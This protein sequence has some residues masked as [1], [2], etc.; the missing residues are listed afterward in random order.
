M[1]DRNGPVGVLDSGIGGFS[2]VRQVQ[3]L[4]PEE[5]ILYFGDGAHVPYGNHPEETIVAMSRY[6]FDF[7]EQRR[8][9]VL[10]VGCNTIS[11]VIEQCMDRV[12]CPVFNAVQAGVEGAARAN[13]GPVGII[14][15]VFTHNCGVYPQQILSQGAR[16]LKVCSRGCPNLAGLVEH[17][18]GSGDGMDQVEKEL[19]R[20]LG[21]LVE[22]EHIQCCVL[23]C[24]HYSL[25]SD[26]IRRMFPQL[27]LV[28]PAWEMA[29]MLK[30]YLQK[31]DL[32]TDR[33]EEGRV[34][35]YTTGDVEEYSLRAKQA[36]LR[37]VE[38]VKAYP[39]LKI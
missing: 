13:G 10:L 31:N 4:L 29:R 12:S 32:F 26:S 9:K 17:N 2:V 27:T 33:T 15:T 14:S 30:E 21:E 16:G 25:V 35:I 24:T 8:V 39:P 23:G 36:G 28:D 20:E 5:N 18:L 11:C 37:Q 3:R 34:S 6:M 38:Q 1:S 19:R 7:M 22:K